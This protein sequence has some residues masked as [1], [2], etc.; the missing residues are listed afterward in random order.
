MTMPTQWHPL[1]VS[2]LRPLIEEFYEVEAGVEVGDAPR[3]ADLVL[4]RRTDRTPTFHAI[5]RHLTTWNV[6]EYK[7]PSV[8]ARLEHVDLLVELGLGIERRLNE[9][10]RKE[11]QT[12]VPPGEVSFWYLTHKIGR[13]LLER[14]AKRLDSLGPESAG[15]WSCSILER[16]M[17][18]VSIIDLPVDAESVVFHILHGEPAETGLSALRLTLTK[19]PLW[20]LYSQVFHSL[21]PDRF[22][23]IVAMARNS[24]KGPVFHIKEMAEHIGMKNVI[25]ELGEKRLIEQIGKEKVMDQFDADDVIDRVFRFMTESERED[26]KRRLH[27]AKKKK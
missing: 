23:E 25:K 19:Q 9:L 5:W 24:K 8:S 17:F 4:L 22:Q 15:I 6:L 11:E 1:F 21:Y 10:G 16:P 7:G 2:L 12:P 14:L 18:L 27:E 20:E 3:Q 26:L 13:R